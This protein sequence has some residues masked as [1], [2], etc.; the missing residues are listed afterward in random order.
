MKLLFCL[1]SEVLSGHLNNPEILS[2]I[3]GTCHN[4]AEQ[5][6]VF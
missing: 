4:I 3:H 1:I 2:S 5:Q 6:S